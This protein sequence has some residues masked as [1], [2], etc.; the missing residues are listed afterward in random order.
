MQKYEYNITIVEY[1]KILRNMTADRPPHNCN[2][3]N[4]NF[5][6]IILWCG[7]YNVLLSF[8]TNIQPKLIHSKFWKFVLIRQKAC[9]IFEAKFVVSFVI[10]ENCWWVDNQIFGGW[11]W[12]PSPLSS[13]LT[14]NPYQAWLRL[15]PSQSWNLIWDLPGTCELNVY[16]FSLATASDASVKP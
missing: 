1:L 13:E 7:N 14:D 2:E 16:V 6:V 8:P 12:P 10:F 4:F 11:R 5:R 15:R 3:Y 9:K